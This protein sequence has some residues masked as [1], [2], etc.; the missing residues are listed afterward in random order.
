MCLDCKGRLLNPS[1]EIFI[2]E[3]EDMEEGEEG[4]EGWWDTQHRRKW[5]SELA[6]VDAKQRLWSDAAP[7]FILCLVGANK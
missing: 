5:E 6:L 3:E 1:Q 4:M 7:L 2:K